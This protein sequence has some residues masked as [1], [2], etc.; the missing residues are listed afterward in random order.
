MVRGHAS[1]V[2]PPEV[3]PLPG[4]AH[5]PGLG[6]IG[7]KL[8]GGPGRGAAADGDAG[9]AAGGDSL[10]GCLDELASGAPGESGWVLGDEEAVAELIRHRGRSPGSD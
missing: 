3:E 5:P 4:H 2:D 6:R 1:L 7:K 8:K 10:F 9:A